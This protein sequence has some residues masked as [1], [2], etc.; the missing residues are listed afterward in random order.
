MMVMTLPQ[1]HVMGMGSPRSTAI[2]ATNVNKSGFMLLTTTEKFLQVK[3]NPADLGLQDDRIHHCSGHAAMHSL[4]GPELGELFL[5]LNVLE[6]P[7]DQ[8]HNV[9]RRFADFPKR[10]QQEG[11]LALS[12]RSLHLER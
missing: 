8:F 3:A 10:N 12:F 2:P 5:V 1:L 4:R 9:V 11:V 6:D 7:L